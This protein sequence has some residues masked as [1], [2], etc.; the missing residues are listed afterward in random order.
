MS[1]NVASSGE[2][3]VLSGPNQQ[4]HGIKMLSYLVNFVEPA[5]VETATFQFHG[6]S[7]VLDL[8]INNIE[9]PYMYKVI[10][11]LER[12]G[13]KFRSGSFINDK[14]YITVAGWV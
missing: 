8:C 7:A 12:Q 3:E 5:K 2:L 9:K 13:W 14:A 11:W 4:H 6:K 1:D 10:T